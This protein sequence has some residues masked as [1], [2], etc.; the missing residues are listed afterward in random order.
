ML[1]WIG[2]RK[3]IKYHL[4]DKSFANRYCVEQVLRVECV[5]NELARVLEGGVSSNYSQ[6][7]GGVGVHLCAD[8]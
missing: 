4:N 8:C 7:V 1:E 6:L 2:V 3:D 5:V